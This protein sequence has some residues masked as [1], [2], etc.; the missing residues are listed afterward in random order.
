[1]AAKTAPAPIATTAPAAA[2]PGA[3]VGVTARDAAAE[4]AAS[5]HQPVAAPPGDM[6][7]VKKRDG[8]RWFYVD[9]QPVTVAAF[10][11]LFDTHAQDGDPNAPVVMV[12]YNEARSYAETRGGRLLSSEE[13]DS[14]STTPGVQLS[15]TL[16]EWIE[17]PGDQ[18]KPKQIRGRGKSM[19][20]PDTG[21]KDVTFRM[22]K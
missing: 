15:G 6:V 17:S 16:F 10:R 22:A 14:A 19:E 21:Y 5:D 1:M 13:W 8:S 11:Q 18:P 9:I 20:R 4:A 7:L 3:V 12:S 2:S